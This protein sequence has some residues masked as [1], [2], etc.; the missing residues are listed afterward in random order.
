LW[1]GAS[2]PASRRRRRRAT[3]ASFKPARDDGEGGETEGAAEGDF[4]DDDM[5]ARSVRR[6]RGRLKPKVLETFD[7]VASEYKRL[8]RLQDQDIQF[9]SKSASLLARARAQVQEAQTNHHR[10]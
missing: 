2:S 5:E 9:S 6:H 7:T 3:R 1:F 8:R 4:D 10:G